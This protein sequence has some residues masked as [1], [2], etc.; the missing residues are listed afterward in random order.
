MDWSTIESALA[1]G[2]DFINE[3][4]PAAAAGGPVAGG[5]GEVIGKIAAFAATALEDAQ[6]EQTVISESD[7]VSIQVSA[8]A[9]Q[10][11]NDKLA[12]DI[13]AS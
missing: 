2:L 1:K 5:I 3:L 8:T 12:A 10:A 11:A 4:A 9:I 7:L 13:A 6:N